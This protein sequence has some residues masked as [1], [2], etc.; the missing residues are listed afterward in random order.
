[1]QDGVRYPYCVVEEF[2]LNK[3][4]RILDHDTMC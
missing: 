2:D 3:V 4:N 1:M